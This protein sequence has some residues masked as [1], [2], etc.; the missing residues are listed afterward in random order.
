MSVRML[1]MTILLA[2]I[3]E[4]VGLVQNGSFETV[5]NGK[6]VG[7]ELPP[8][9]RVVDREGM[10]GTR[11]VLF[12]NVSDRKSHGFPKMKL[13][14]E[15]G[16]CYE[17]SIWIKSENA[18]TRPRIMVEWYDAN[19]KWLG[20]SYHPVDAGTHDWR[21]VKDKTPPIPSDAKS[22]FLGFDVAKG[23][24]G[25]VW[26]DDVSVKL[27]EHEPFGGFYSSC[28]RDIASEG[29]VVFY[30]AINLKDHP[31]AKVMIGYLDAEG[32]ARHL[33]A[34]RIG[35]DA[36]ILKV[37]AAHLAKGTHPV[38]C[39]VV[40]GD[41]TRLGGGS[42]MFTRVSKLPN[43]RVWIDSKRRTIVDGKPFF[44]VGI[45]L[46]GVNDKF[47]QLTNFRTGPFNCIMPYHAP[48]AQ[49]LDWLRTQ[50]I[51]VIYPINN[52]WP[53]HDYR[54]KGVETDDD[55]QTAVEREVN[56]VKDH[57][58]ILAWYV[59]DEISIEKFPQLLARQK[60]LERIDPGHPT[61]TVLYQVSS[62]REYYPT[63]DIIGS[64]P[65]PIPHG[66]IGTVAAWT[67]TTYNEVMGLKPIWQVPQAF[68]WGDWSR[69]KGDTRRFPTREEL[70]NMTWQCIANGANGIVYWCYRLLYQNGKFRVDRWADICAA[71]NGVKPYAPVFLSEEDAPKVRGATESLSVRAWRYQGDVYL[72]VVNNTRN[73]VKGEIGVD[74]VDG[75][76]LQRL[77][78]YDGCVLRSCENVSVELPGLGYT[79][80]RLGGNWR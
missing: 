42:L 14:L 17:Y 18:T 70:D 28:Y 69:K 52:I 19:G 48:S 74:N 6:P 16:K 51:E 79:F 12:E 27:F 35:T 38:M 29:E 7:W 30:A 71:A 32:I 68:S 64:D 80:A 60:L 75:M 73:P 26:F 57:P 2:S 20:G 36:A 34:T 61:W 76:V 46:N 13:P 67:R 54:P 53:W 40:D 39:E 3:C 23:G 1:M 62:I 21:E 37:N 47:S 24:Q 44:P 59:N 31:F 4:G 33:P 9:Y 78:G 65:Y 58:A 15:A 41:G 50:G 72:A 56:A 25:K 43:R 55:A 77:Q 22:C 10:N 11:G 63:F 5:E 49:W 66:S 45:Y 8:L